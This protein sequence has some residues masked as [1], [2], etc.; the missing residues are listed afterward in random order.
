MN[1]APRPI[2]ARVAISMSG[3]DASDAS[4]ENVPNQISPNR[5]AYLRPNR[6]PSDPAVSKRH[7]NTIVYASTIH[8]R[9]EP[10]A[11]RSRTMVGSA[12]LS[13]VLS[14]PITTTHIDSTHSVHQR[15]EGGGSAID[16][17][18]GWANQLSS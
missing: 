16:S 17:S 3:D 9:S 1:A 14:M 12:T 11:P 7:A 10:V 5:S 18:T 2:R 8:W 13:T 15:R 4:A 6:S